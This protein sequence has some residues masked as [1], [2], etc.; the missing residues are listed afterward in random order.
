MGDRGSILLSN[1]LPTSVFSLASVLSGND[2]I[3]TGVGNDI[4]VGGGKADPIHAGAGDNIVLGDDGTLSFVGGAF[5][6][7][8]LQLGLT[9][10]NDLITTLAGRDSIY[11]GD[12]DNRVNAGGGNDD[13]FAGVGID[14]LNGEDGDDFIVGNMGDDTINGGAGNDELFGGMAAWVRSDF[15]LGSNDF[16]L[17][18]EYSITEALYSSSTTSF[19]LPNIASGAWTPSVRI[20]PTIFGG[21]SIDGV[22]GDGRD[23]IN[24]GAGHDVM[25]GGFD[26]DTLSGDAGNDYIDAGAG[27]DVNVN[28]GDD[29]DVVRGGA[30]N[31]VVN[32]SNGIDNL[33]GDDGEDQLYGG[34]GDGSGSQAG[35]RLYGGAGRDQLYA[36]APA[37]AN[38]AAF[39]AQN[40]LAGDQLFGGDGGDFL[41]GNARREV[42]GGDGGNDYIAGDA[43]V[44]PS[45]LTHT[46][47]NI[48]TQ[49]DTNGAA[50][51]LVGGAGED[52]LYGGG[53]NDALWGGSGSDLIEGQ[54]GTDL[55]YG[56]AGI[57]LFTINTSEPGI[58][59]TLDGHYGNSVQGDVEDDNATDIAMVVGTT[60]PDTILLGGNSLNSRQ[61]LLRYNTSTIAID[62]RSTTGSLLIEQFRIA[63]LAQN[64][65]LGF[66]TLAA[67]DAGI[68]SP[69]G[70]GLPS[71]FSVLDTSSLNARSR[72]YVGVF[73]GNSGDDILVGSAGRD[74]LDGG[75][76]SD[77][78]YGFAGDDR[79]WGD[80]GNGS[81]N[82][83]DELYAGAGN[84]DLIGGL[85]TNKLYAWSFDPQPAGDTQFGV[86]VDAQG[87]LFNN[88]GGGVRSL[89]NTG[90]NRLLGSQRND[91]LYGGTIVD[92]MYGN[93][94]T[95]V[96]YRSNG[97]T[98][99]SMDGTLAGDEWKAYARES[100]QVWY[101]GGT[102]AADEINLNYVTEPGLLT[103]HHLITRLT[104]NN[105]NFSFAAQI[106]LDFEATDSDGNPIWDP[107]RLKFRLDELQAN[108]DPAARESELRKIS[109]ATTDVTN[110]Q[111]LA[112]LIPPEGDFQV[113]LIDA[114]GGNDHVTVGPTVQK[115]VWVD[116]GAGDDQVEILA[117]NAI[118][119]DKTEKS[120]GNGVSGRNDIPTQAYTLTNVVGG[121][122]RT[123]SGLAASADGLEFNGLTMDNPA[124]IDWYRFTLAAAPTAN[125]VVQLASGSPIDGLGMEIFSGLPLGAAISGASNAGPIVI[126]TTS[127]AGL[128]NGQAVF[129][130][131]A[132]GNLATNG[133]H[134]VRV[135]SPTTFELFSDSALTVPRVGNGNY[136]GGGAW[137]T[138]LFGG[139]TAG[140][141]GS[142]S[143]SGLLANT[144]YLLRVTS[145]NLVPTPYSLRLN[146]TGTANPTNLA[147]MPK[148]NLGIRSGAADR[149]DVILGGTGD[150][151]LRG[152]AGEDW[153]FGNDGNDVLVGGDDRQASDLL[154]G[155]NGNDT[156]QIITDALPLLGNQPNTDFDPAT[157][158]MLPTY[159]DQFIGGEGIDRVLYLGGDKDRRGFDVPDFA[160]L[161]YNTL[162]HRYEFSALVWDIGTQSFRTQSTPNGTA[163]V[164]EFA[165]YQ[166]R[167]VEQTQ[168]ELRA[169]N[170]TFHANPGFQFLPLTSPPNAADFDT[171]G[172]ELGD[173]EQGATEA[174]LTING[175]AGDDRLF[176]GVLGDVINGGAGN[177]TVVGN[178]G[179]DDV[180][181]GGGDDLLFGNIPNST[182]AT[183]PVIFGLPA[184][185]PA[186]AASEAYVYDL[187]APYLEIAVPPRDGVSLQDVPNGANTLPKPLVYLSFN[188]S[189]NLGMDSSGNGNNAT[190]NGISR[191]TSWNN[192]N[193]ASFNNSNSWVQLGASGVNAGSNWTASAWFQGLVTSNAF[194]TLFED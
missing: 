150:D 4:I 13:V 193:S 84:D 136:T 173:F 39:Q 147:A 81:T 108:P 100:D 164:Q 183:I 151:V 97:T 63:G 168:I 38:F 5:S 79:L 186:G 171:W 176:G 15:E 162:L 25:L 69:S 56:G 163:Y 123:A 106:R 129:V 50:D 9:D 98:F 128:T 182:I 185:F 141:A 83:S 161:Q 184:G 188:D 96:L 82:D 178:L 111:L 145:P 14:T 132:T 180:Q 75:I 40:L 95:D 60:G 37:M 21:L 41:Y 144:A 16:D 114:L 143:L 3:N 112:R 62:I 6:S 53:G 73:D 191:G 90:L 103:D 165:Y 124:D 33:Y 154:F 67:V 55:Q 115:S 11:T 47:A 88:D 125:S 36:F 159:S 45:Y 110:E 121:Q 116:A 152:G 64:D 43:Y 190:L 174:A 120:S 48:G 22:A 78:L 131:N 30:G 170:D 17:P 119:V 138:R 181:G 105:G 139:S 52:Q 172:I 135:T 65:T 51:V 177:D 76:G 126:T 122:L 137:T 93:G 140:D 156:F 101:V 149:R 54:S 175:G 2:T 104:N 66:Y 7:V 29:D 18:P 57:D 27:N 146:L 35:Q 192:G 58:I 70:L 158:T 117:G 127:T 20:T 160:A 59:D 24:G 130:S 42:L 89:E 44:G 99:E 155:G 19:G 31:D 194:N 102:N 157:Q 28:G 153:I 169:G 91:S 61:A 26:V 134:Y 85:G 87:R 187:A 77:K 118:L 94:G 109:N 1:S 167:D 86:Y 74:Q 113:I 166:T 49:A 107:D 12:G 72:D 142:I 71:N 92:F 32:G 46:L 34:A 10:G 80:I 133:T 189:S 8:S 23:T 148:V 179:D 68:L